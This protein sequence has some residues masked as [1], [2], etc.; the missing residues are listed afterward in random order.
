MV[1]ELDKFFSINDW[2]KDPAMS[3]WVPRVYDKIG[4]D[5]T[6]TFEIN[7]C[8]KFN[9]LMMKSGD[10]IGDVYCASFPTPEILQKVLEEKSE[11]ALLFLHHP[12]DIEVSRAGFLPISPND[13]GCLKEKRISV[14]AC[15]APMDCLDKMGTN[16][17]IMKASISKLKD[18]L[19]NM[20]MDLQEGFAPLLLS[21]EKG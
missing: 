14:Y 7:F 9:G 12:I 15:H 16:A 17:A 5:Y 18:T 21:I 4:F 10:T 6:K 3:R 13:L 19:H 8:K 20:A 11:N 1:S 2:E